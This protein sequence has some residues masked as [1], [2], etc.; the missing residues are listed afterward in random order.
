MF[1]TKPTESPSSLIDQA[2]RTADVAIHNTQRATNDAIGG[3]VDSIDHA[4]QQVTPM[5]NN[6]GEKASAF[7]HNGLD[8]VRQTSRQL[9]DG[10]HYASDKTVAYIREEPVKAM[11][12]A[13][14]S[15]AA[16]MALARVISQSNQSR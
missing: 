15:G 11:L 5:I 1:N 2:A 14:A 12:I 4:R 9:R 13:A 6:A 3:L 10:A 8:S 16:V 7:V